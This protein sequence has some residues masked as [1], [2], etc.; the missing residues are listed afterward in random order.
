MINP[1]RELGGAADSLLKTMKGWGLDRRDA[2]GL[3]GHLEIGLRRKLPRNQKLELIFS[4][5]EPDLV[6]KSAG[7]RD[8]GHH[9][10]QHRYRH[11]PLF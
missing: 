1:V 8:P 4:R 11:I 7:L 5:V 2:Q 9:C 3:V 6:S 10:C